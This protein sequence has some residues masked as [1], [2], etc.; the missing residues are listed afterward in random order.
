MGLL[1]V[2]IVAAV[3]VMILAVMAMKKQ[4][5]AKEESEKALE[6]IFDSGFVVSKKLPFGA[7]GSILYVD[8]QNKKWCLLKSKLD[9]NPQVYDFSDLFEFE[10]LEDGGSIAKGTTKGKVSGKTGGAIVGG[11]LF[12]PVGAV[13]GSAGKRKIKSKTTTV[14]KNTCTNL[15]VRIVL[16]DL[17]ASPMIFSF[18]SSEVTTDSFSYRVNIEN[19]RNLATTLAYIQSGKKDEE[20][21]QEQLETEKNNDSNNSVE[22]LEKLFELKEKGV[23]SEEEFEAKKKQILGL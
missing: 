1:I 3:G 10:I 18:I 14:T 16:K 20:L 23:I 15:Q 4:A 11:L 2:F 22:N 17:Q 21:M 9:T 8:D 13:I 7:D 5:E 12:G 6:T 19:A